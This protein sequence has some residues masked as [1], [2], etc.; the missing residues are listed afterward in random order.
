MTRRAKVILILAVGLAPG[1]GGCSAPVSPS[2]PPPASPA[3]TSLAITG[4]PEPLLFDVPSS[5]QA[6]RS[7]TVGAIASFDDGSTAAVKASSV[8]WST[9]D[10][11]V[12]SFSGNTLQAFREGAIRIVVADGGFTASRDLTVRPSGAIVREDRNERI[13]SCGRRVCPYPYCPA[14]G[15]YWLFPVY[16]GGTIELVSVKNPG[17]GSPSNYVTQLSPKGE[18]V[19]SWLLLP[20]NPQFKTASV[21]GGFMYVFTM[22]ADLSVCGDVAAVWTHP[23]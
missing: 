9:T 1:S 7:Y 18:Y 23:N 13:T 5:V 19:R 10:P 16:E 22:N 6:G 12:A 20:A 17:W 15:P 3:M 8:T 14:T 2:S 21:P 11:T 4:L